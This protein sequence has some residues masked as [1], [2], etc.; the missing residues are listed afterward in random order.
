[1]RE[2]IATA[3]VGCQAQLWDRCVN[4]SDRTRELVDVRQRYAMPFRD[5]I[6]SGAQGAGLEEAYVF[7]LIRQESRFITDARS[8]VG[9]GG[10]MQLMPATARWTAK[11]IGVDLSPG[12]NDI[13]TNVALGTAYLRML[14]D[15]FDGHEALAAAGYNAGPG[16]PRKWRAMGIGRSAVEAAVFAENVPFNETRDYVKRVLSN[17]TVYAALISGQPQSLKARLQAVAARG[18]TLPNRD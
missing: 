6:K 7:G 17:A 3:E 1:D 11:K 4:T 9:A 13:G 15:E 8:S 16:R 12:V 2:L 18:M 5:A 10:L 14:K